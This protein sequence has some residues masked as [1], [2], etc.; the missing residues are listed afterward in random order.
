VVDV[1]LEDDGNEDD[2]ERNKDTPISVEVAIGKGIEVN[3]LVVDM[4]IVLCEGAEL[5]IVQSF[6]EESVVHT[7]LILI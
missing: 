5:I 3:E 4:A 1:L 6:A 7:H 2:C